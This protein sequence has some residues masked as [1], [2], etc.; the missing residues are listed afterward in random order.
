MSLVKYIKRS[1]PSTLMF[2]MCI[3]NL[4]N[5]LKITKIKRWYLIVEID[6]AHSKNVTEVLKHFCTIW[7]GSKKKSSEKVEKCKSSSGYS[8]SSKILINYTYLS[9]HGGEKKGFFSPPVWGDIKTLFLSWKFSKTVKK[10]KLVWSICFFDL[11]SLRF[12]I[13]NPPIN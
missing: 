13:I 10:K 11:K 2:V 6:S 5:K 7:V 4:K 3:K 9:P 8:S 12:N 1:Y